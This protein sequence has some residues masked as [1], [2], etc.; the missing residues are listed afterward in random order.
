MLNREAGSERFR[1]FYKRIWPALLKLEDE[2]KELYCA[3]NGRPAESPVRLLGVSILQYMEKLPD[4]QAVEALTFDLRWKSAIGMDVDERGFH[5][6]VL[7]RFRERLLKAGKEQIGFD[8]ALEVLRSAGYLGKKTPQRLDSTHVLG[9]LAHMSRLECVRET[10]RLA[11]EGLE[12][13]SRLVRPAGWALWWERYVE[14]KPDYKEK[15]TIFAEKLT[16]AGQ[17][18]KELLTWADELEDRLKKDEAVELLRRVF[19][20]NFTYEIDGKVEKQRA[21]PSGAVHNPHE[22]E[23]QWSAKQ[24]S[25]PMEWIGYK[26]QIA[27]TV[28]EMTRAKGEPTKAVI[29]AIVTQEAIASDKSALPVVEEA[30]QA[31]GQ[32]PPVK[33][34]ADAGYTSGAELARAEGEGRQLCG[35]V[36]PPPAKEG[37]YSSEDFTISIQTRTALCPAGEESTN[38]S[39][40]ENKETCDVAYR[41]EWKRKLCGG[42][43]QSSKCFGKSQSHRTLVVGQ[44]HELVQ[45]RRQEQKTDEF[46]QGFSGTFAKPIPDVS[47]ISISGLSLISISDPSPKSIPHPSPSLGQSA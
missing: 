7:V 34:Y 12:Q 15:E 1:F 10:M 44:H 47:R 26:A 46:K 6:T 32:E 33:V 25:K 31:V 22:P 39:R 13:E 21:Q 20:E 42:C 3:D 9:L 27:E 17:D 18:I 8:A 5:S 16:Q 41:F 45:R 43:E 23:A 38:C 14:S 36:A 11:L 19:G 40:L 28:E 29:T 37:R 24:T 4:R 35:P 30:W 2:L